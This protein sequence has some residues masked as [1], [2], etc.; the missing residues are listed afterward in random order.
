[1]RDATPEKSTG[2]QKV[3][4]AFREERG[5]ALCRL[6]IPAYRMLPRL[7]LWLAIRC[8]IWGRLPDVDLMT[9]TCSATFTNLMF[10]GPRWMGETTFQYLT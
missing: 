7:F 5:F 8:W 3:L 9:P 10:V 6:D 4:S 1:M 2:E